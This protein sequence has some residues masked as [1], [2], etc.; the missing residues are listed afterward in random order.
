MK[1]CNERDST[2][3]LPPNEN[4]EIYSDCTN[5]GPMPTTK[6]ERWNAIINLTSASPKHHCLQIS[7]KKSVETI[8]C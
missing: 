4:P 3:N 1:E 5:L 2:I 8:R 7:T 6:A